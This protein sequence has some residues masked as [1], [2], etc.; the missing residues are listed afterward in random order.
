MTV[1]GHLTIWRRARRNIARQGTVVLAP[2]RLRGSSRALSWSII[3]MHSSL[4][5]NLQLYWTKRGKN[6]DPIDCSSGV[7]S[8]R[9]RRVGIFA[10]SPVTES[11][12]NESGDGAWTY[13]H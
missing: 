4:V 1:P 13:Q 10:F 5:S 7:V 12:G 2:G 3:R 9:W 11:N 8:T 6:V